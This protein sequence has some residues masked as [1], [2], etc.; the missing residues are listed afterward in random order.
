LFN[1]DD[2]AS[3]SINGTPVVQATFGQDTGIVDVTPFIQAGQNNLTFTLDNT[4]RGYSYGFDV[5]RD[6]ALY[7]REQCGI[8]NAFG[9]NSNDQTLG[10]V[11]TRTL[12]LRP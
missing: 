8:F 2:V 12:M 7:F 3:L 5:Y 11:Y 4:Q 6:G 9:C 1:T 10:Q